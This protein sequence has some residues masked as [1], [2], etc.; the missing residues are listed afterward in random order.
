LHSWEPG[1]DGRLTAVQPSSGGGE[2][3]TLRVLRT[4]TGT[5]LGPTVHG[6]RYSHVAWVPTV[7]ERSC[8]H[9]TGSDGSLHLYYVR[10]DGERGVRGVWLRRVACGTDTLVHACTEPGT[11]PGVRVRNDRWLL[12]TESHGT[13]HRTDLWLADLSR[14]CWKQ[15][16]LRAL[17]EG[18][19][20]ETEV[21]LGANGLLY[22]RTTWGAPRS[23]ICSVDPSEPE[24]RYWR[25]IVPE[26]SRTSLDAFTPFTID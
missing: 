24:S 21:R 20:A 9:R 1:P 6:V 14:G 11:V 26:Y 19:D 25:E 22:L 17:Q 16:H 12:I 23:R 3:G 5:Q 4:D 2:R 18:I 15:P 10:R 8:P 13:G 7:Y